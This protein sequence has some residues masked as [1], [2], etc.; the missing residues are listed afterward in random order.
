MHLPYDMS[1]CVTTNC[2]LADRCRRKEPGHPTYQSFT[3]FP[4]GEDCHGF[5]PRDEEENK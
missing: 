2:P 1:R 5:W 4:G 3:A